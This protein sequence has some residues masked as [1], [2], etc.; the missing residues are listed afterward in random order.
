MDNYDRG[1]VD[2]F[3]SEVGRFNEGM[4][5]VGLRYKRV[6]LHIHTPASGDYKD[7]GATPE[8]IVDAALKAD[9]A[10]IA[11]TD[12]QTG[13]WADGLK[14]AAEK[15]PLVVFPGVELLVT[16][17]EEG[18]HVLCLFSE[19]KG[20]DHVNQFLNTL[21]VYDKE[22]KKTL[23]TEL[24]VGQ[25]A[26]RLD[27]YDASGI[28]ILA[29]CHSTKG[30]LGDIKGETRRAIF[31]KP[32]HCLIGAEASEANFRDADKK[33]K[34]TRVVDLLDGN[35]PN[36]HYRR[37]GVVQSSDSHSLDTIGSTCSFFKVESNI[38]LEDIRQCLVDR[39]TRIRQP[40][41]YAEISYPIVQSLEVTGGFLSDQSFAFNNGLNSI[42]GAKGSGKSLCVEFL[43][44]VLNQSPSNPDLKLDHEQ[45]LANCLETYGKVSAILCDESGKRYKVER[46]LKPNEG[47]L[48]VVR[49]I[50]A[51]NEVHFEVAEAF[52]VLFLSQNEIIKIAEDKSGR[53]QRHFIDRFFDFYKYVRNT[54]RALSDLIEADRRYS[55]ALRAHYKVRSVEERKK[56]VQQQLGVAERQLTNK[57]FTEYQKKESIGR[58]LV[59]QRNYLEGLKGEVEDFI[60]EIEDLTS[61]EIEGEDANNDPGVKR[62][63]D[64]VNSTH[65]AVVSGL[66]DLAKTVAAGVVSIVKEIA[67][68]EK[69]FAPVKQEYDKLVKQAGGNQVVLSEQRKNI[70]A[71][72][73]KLDAEI[74]LLKGKASLLRTITERRRQIV[75]RLE[76][77][78]KAYFEARKTRCDYFNSSS[79]GLLNVEMSEQADTSIFAENLLRFKKGSW[80]RDE[81]MQAIA[82]KV[83][84]RDLIRSILAYEW[85]GRKT[86]DEARCISEPSNVEQEKILKLFNHL[87]DSYSY[88]DILALQ[89][90]STPDDKPSISYRVGSEYK[91]LAE[92]STGQKAVA[93]LLMALSDGKFPIVID[94][95]EDSLDLRSIWEDVCYKVRNTKERRQFIFTTHNSSV[96]VAS[97]SDSFC[98][99]EADA[100]SGRVLLTGSMNQPDIRDQVIKYLEGG[101]STYDHKRKKYNL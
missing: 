37:L 26:D 86:T 3:F 61:P 31:E 57:A 50:E 28:M 100:S 23:C 51:G 69:T 2:R 92:L 48:V 6:D 41:E 25:V 93:L 38:T 91:P 88:E 29:H 33:K 56:S 39:D 35:D 24:S 49:D 71:Q 83:A 66:K 81:E 45:K 55:E 59:N 90:K 44:F 1:G 7:K 46:E 96:A 75:S 4:K 13:D 11:V 40:H 52:P 73:G 89:H 58:A 99:M 77:N 27:A 34:K 67:D 8:Q 19:E 15:T 54:E 16:G 82:S 98:I 76:E 101:P 68:F 17:G 20:T 12:H 94:Q 9:L 43:R 72:L 32:R 30:V 60:P 84:P 70:V 74:A 85:K 18:V 64:V 42:L 78:R 5:V 80:L 95:P 79:G 53:E 97:D 21:E 14:S 63:A 65:T 10:A 22:G 62:T 36:Y 47:S 87:L